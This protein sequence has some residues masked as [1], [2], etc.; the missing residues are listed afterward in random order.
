MATGR[1]ND[2]SD[3]DE[4]TWPNPQLE[5]EVLTARIRYMKKKS[6]WESGTFV[7]PAPVQSEETD[8]LPFYPLV[9]MSV[10]EQTGLVL[11]QTIA[12]ENWPENLLRQFA[13][14]IVADDICPWMIRI[15][16]DR[17]YALLED[18]CERTGIRLNREDGL[19]LYEEAKANL[20]HHLREQTRP[21][22][23]EH[24]ATVSIRE[25]QDGLDHFCE[26]LMKMRDEELLLM[27]INL[28]KI[29]YDL[30]EMDAVPNELIMRLE[31]L[32]GQRK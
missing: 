27:P 29:L 22:V 16:D 26:T 10:D 11:Q 13:E 25:E 9:L 4:K 17:A 31:K 28:V 15:A 24:E 1:W 7:L 19:D 12:P 21:A 8:R 30:K 20:L 6:V 23:P 3:S 18:L 2:S 14:Q 32:F 5:N